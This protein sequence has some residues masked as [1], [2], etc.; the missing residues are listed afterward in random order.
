MKHKI[1][2]IL[3]SLFVISCDEDP[4]EP[5]M[6]MDVSLLDIPY[7]PETYILE[8]IPNFP[9]LE[10]PE[11][12]QLTKDGV[13]LG[14]HLFFDPI[15]SVDSTKSCASCHSPEL[16]FTDGEALSQGVG[17][18]FG[19]RSSMSLLNIGY[20]YT[21]LFWDGRSPSLE[22]Q[23]IHPVENMLEL[24]HNWPDLVQKFK[25][26][27]E[28][29]SMFRK[30]FGIETTAGITQELTTKALAQYERILQ[31]GNSK[32]D[33]VLQGT[34]VFT[35]QELDGYDMFFD[36]NEL[37][38][39]AEC[40]HCHAA[41][42]FSDNSFKNN[43]LD[44]ID[45]LADFVDPGYG[46]V[47]GNVLFNGQFRVPSL[48]NVA[49]TAPYMHDGRFE[50]LEDVLDHYISGGKPSLNKDQILYPLNINEEQKASLLAFLHTLT[51]TSYVD[52]ELFRSPFD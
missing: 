52:N 25:K 36:R 26:H 18:V 13:Q 47:V 4:V 6:Q 24:N 49:L 17:G 12:N 51:D 22:E 34:N 46:E 43:G 5:E 38:P 35:D 44:S 32:F 42:L 33:Q 27:P 9:I 19:T 1:I 28:Y 40:A 23:A 37:L 29:P 31:S 45:N 50:T 14:R 15:M 48:R 41:P 3:L 2:F 11:D 30:A 21:G 10:I 8:P 39:D 16:S 7:N 20:V